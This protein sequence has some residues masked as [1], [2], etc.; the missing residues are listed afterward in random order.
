[1]TVENCINVR[2]IA[3]VVKTKILRH[4]PHIMCASLHI[5]IGISYMK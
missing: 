4:V 1:M 5:Y 2:I 3:T